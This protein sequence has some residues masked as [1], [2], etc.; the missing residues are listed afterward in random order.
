MW[1]GLASVRAALYPITDGAGHEECPKTGR[2][3][4]LISC[5]NFIFATEIRSAEPVM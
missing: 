3:L 1:K 5:Q 2:S 4:P